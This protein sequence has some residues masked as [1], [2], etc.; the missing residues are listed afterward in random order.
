MPVIATIVK[1]IS[2]RIINDTRKPDQE[3]KYN[4][5]LAG[6]LSVKRILFKKRAYMTLRDFKYCL[7]YTYVYVSLGQINEIILVI[8]DIWYDMA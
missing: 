8:H 1:F 4:T 7:Y 2:L 3:R 6:I 5:N